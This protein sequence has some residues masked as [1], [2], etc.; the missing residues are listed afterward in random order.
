MAKKH[1]NANAD[2][3]VEAISK[4]ENFI[5]KHKTKLIIA[6]AIAVCAV[7]GYFIYQGIQQKKDKAGVEAFISPENNSLMKAESDSLDL[8][9]FES[10]MTEHEGHTVSIAPFETAVAAYNSGEYRKAIKYFEQYKGNDKI[11]NARAKAC[12]GDCHVQLG[13]YDKALSSYDS[14]VE[15]EDG[16][17]TPEYAFRAALVAEKLGKNEEAIEYFTL[18]KNEYPESPRAADMD[19]YI[20]RNEAK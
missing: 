18:I 20:A 1:N 5:I 19:K 13:E 16:F 17:W 3:P 8:S 15:I 2:T 12:I 10:Y 7:I 9:N 6:T 4:T 14:A 11:Y